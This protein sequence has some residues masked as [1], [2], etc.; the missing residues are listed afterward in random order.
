MHALHMHSTC[1]P[2]EQDIQ[3]RLAKLRK[4]QGEADAA[5]AAAWS[6][7]KSYVEDL[8]DW[9]APDP[10]SSVNFP[11]RCT[12][13]GMG[14]FVLTHTCQFLSQG[15]VSGRGTDQQVILP[16]AERMYNARESEEV[17]GVWV[18]R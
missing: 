7:L 9:M 13:D 10:H 18:G 8:T 11:G 14:G 12:M 16:C 6:K 5:R 1:T 15:A 2:W 17:G 3:A 4:E